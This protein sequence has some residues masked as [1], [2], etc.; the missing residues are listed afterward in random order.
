MFHIGSKG[1]KLLELDLKIPSTRLV[2]TTT[3][4]IYP[5]VL[6]NLLQADAIYSLGLL[7]PLVVHNYYSQ[8][9]V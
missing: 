3:N 6:E 2:P 5:I 1:S 8:V 7:F 9:E 4:K